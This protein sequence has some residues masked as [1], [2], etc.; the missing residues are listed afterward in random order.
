MT[1]SQ[2]TALTAYSPTSNTEEYFSQSDQAELGRLSKL[3]GLGDVMYED[4]EHAAMLEDLKGIGLDDID[5]R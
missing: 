4:P 2:M 3:N 1:Y 5:S